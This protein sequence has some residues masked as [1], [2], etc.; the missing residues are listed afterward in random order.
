MV[1]NSHFGLSP[2]HLNLW[3]KPSLLDTNTYNFYMSKLEF[4]NSTCVYQKWKPLYLKKGF[5]RKTAL[6][7]DLRMLWDT[8]TISL[9]YH[10]LEKNYFLYFCNYDTVPWE[11]PLYTSTKIHATIFY[12]NGVY[13]DRYLLQQTITTTYF[14]CDG[15]VCERIKCYMTQIS[16]L[17]DTRFTYI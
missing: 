6:I 14:H 4:V 12:N 8:T 13:C 5:F 2:I 3:T 9:T 15:Q 16:L 7:Q 10:V 11:T 17:V 1:L